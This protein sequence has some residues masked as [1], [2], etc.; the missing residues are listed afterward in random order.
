ME[1]F[2]SRDSG[3]IH[4]LRIERELG[5]VNW[6]YA[7][8]RTQSGLTYAADNTVFLDDKLVEYQSSISL[9]VNEDISDVMTVDPNLTAETTR[10]DLSELTVDVLAP[11]VFMVG[12]NDYSLFIK[13]NDQLI[14][15]S[16]YAGLR[17]R[18]DALLDFLGEPLPLAHL[19]VTN[20]HGDQLD[21]VADA[22][23][24][25]A[26]V[27][28]SLQTQNALGELR[29]DPIAINIVEDGTSLGPLTLLLKPS[30][31]AVENVFALHP[32]SGVLFQDGHYHAL[33]QD[34]AT[35]V[36]P[37]ARE[38]YYLITELQIDVGRL[39]SGHGRKAEDWPLFEHAVQKPG[40]G[41]LCRSDRRI[42]S[43][44][45]MGSLQVQ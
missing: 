25:G 3:L 19:V 36:Q 38:L 39:V 42:C 12:Q 5:I 24:L 15:V 27:W 10:V 22:L 21:G 28:G 17:S 6:I 35:W 26:D 8:H 40:A 9:C 37:A 13:D 29:T 32:D 31:Y 20:H 43:A 30:S 14:A 11:D 4:R 18:Y 41:L 16:S 45:S 2:V 44:G 33:F 34:Q 7:N 23:E 1:I